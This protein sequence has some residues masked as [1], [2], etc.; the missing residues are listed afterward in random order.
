MKI[1]NLMSACSNWNMK[2]TIEFKSKYFDTSMQPIWLFPH[3]SLQ[4][5]CCFLNRVISA[6]VFD[7]RQFLEC[8]KMKLG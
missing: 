1:A 7:K 6:K 3:T 2:G 4:C 8:C 5:Y